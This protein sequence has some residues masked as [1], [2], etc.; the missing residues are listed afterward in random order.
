VCSH[1][2]ALVCA[3]RSRDQNV[4]SC[5]QQQVPGSRYAPRGRSLVHEQERARARHATELVRE[6]LPTTLLDSVEVW[7]ALL[8]S[9][10]GM[11]VDDRDWVGVNFQA[12]FQASALL[13]G[14]IPPE[15][16]GFGSR[17][18]LR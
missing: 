3:A 18:P 2:D 17:L 10:R 12:G 9:G 1:P 4:P 7:K 16:S 6:H 8:T 15:M 11:P 14:A 5:S 13:S